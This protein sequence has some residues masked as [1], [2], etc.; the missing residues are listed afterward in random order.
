MTLPSVSDLKAQAR[1]LR[2]A[3]ASNGQTVS[4]SQALELLSA[5]YGYRD[6]NTVCAAAVSET[7]QPFAIGDRV[8]G[9]YMRQ[10]FSGEVRGLSKLAQSGHF[11][12]T[13]QFDQPV[14]VV[15]FDS[16][17]AHRSRV[18]S[19]IRRDGVSVSKTSDGEPHLNLKLPR[20]EQ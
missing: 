4:H 13:L 3:L 9:T 1:R 6:W 11:R 14:D 16:F 7:R 17:S 8:T 12:V 15:S 19:V 10:P 18:T 2:T 20:P 5:Q